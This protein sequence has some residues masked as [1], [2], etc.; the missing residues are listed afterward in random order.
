MGIGS[1]ECKK[2]ES[3][4]RMVYVESA[5][6]GQGEYAGNNIQQVCYQSVSF[7]PII[8]WKELHW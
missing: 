8:L 1:S 6:L 3:D 7:D 2:Q 5:V 4:T